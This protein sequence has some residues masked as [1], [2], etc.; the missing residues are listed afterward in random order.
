LGISSTTGASLTA[1][2][3]KVATSLSDK[4]PSLAVKVI[5]SLPFQSAV[6][7]VIV[8]IL[9]E[10]N[11]VSCELPEYVQEISESAL[12]TSKTKLSSAIVVNDDPSAIVWLGISATTGASLTAD[13]VNVAGSLSVRG[14]SLAVKVIV[15]LP[16]QL[17]LGIE[18]VAILLTID[19]VS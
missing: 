6:G 5:V 3:V 4:S 1:V 8:A 15:S 17:I 11:T 9:E 14:P 12:S 10:I 7:T 18:I 19:T 2:T 13:T 16:D